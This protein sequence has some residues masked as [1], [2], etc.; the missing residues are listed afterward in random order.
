MEPRKLRIHDHDDVPATRVPPKT[1][2]R[3]R[4]VRASL[5]T[6]LDIAGLANHLGVTP[7]HVR[8]LIAERRIPYLKWGRL[9]RFDPDEIAAWL[10]ATRKKAA[11][12]SPETAAKRGGWRS[13]GQV[14]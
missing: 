13:D 7:R 10:D 1:G 8:R 14:G 2:P 4:D 12:P 11:A 9:I 3:E 5:P 6:L